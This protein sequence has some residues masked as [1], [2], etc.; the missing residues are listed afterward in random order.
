MSVWRHDWAWA[1][2]RQLPGTKVSP[3][4]RSR[5]KKWA[6]TLSASHWMKG[7]KLPLPAMSSLSLPGEGAES[8]GVVA[9]FTRC[10]LFDLYLLANV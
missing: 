2:L 1:F 9:G 8:G 4:W 10:R 3:F 7:L 5:C 6:W